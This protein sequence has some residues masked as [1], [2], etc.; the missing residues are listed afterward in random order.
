MQDERYKTCEFW[1]ERARTT[2]GPAAVHTHS[3]SARYDAWARA[4]LKRWTLKRL[5]SIEPRYRRCLDLGCGHGDWTELLATVSDEVFACDVAPAFVAQARTRVP[6]ATVACADVREYPMPPRLD[7]VY[8]G[9]VLMHLHDADAIDVLRRVRSVTRPGAVVVI[10]D[11]CTF[12]LGRRTEV[13][14]ARYFSV[15]RRPG[16]LSALA[17]RVGLRPIELRSSPSIYAEVMSRRIPLIRWPLRV[18]WRLATL[19]WLRA[20]HTLLLR[21]F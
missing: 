7:L 4:M 12:N 20:S 18:L 21:A 14:D 9:A 17:D 13:P 5:R 8:L 1:I 11:W 6:H 3:R 10:R 16:E 19:H 2:A 15:H